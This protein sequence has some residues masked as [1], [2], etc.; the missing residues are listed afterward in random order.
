[1]HDTLAATEMNTLLAALPRKV[2]Q[3]LRPDLLPVT[4]VFGVV[5]QEPGEPI[6]HVYFPLNCLVSLLTV[7]EN[8]LALEVGMVGR[9]GMVGVSLA[10][11]ITASPVRA[12]VQGAGPALQMSAARFMSAFRGSPALQRGLHGYIHRLM[13][14]I[15]QTAAC[16]RFH[17]VEA[18]LAKW[19]LMTRDRVGSGE[20]QMTQEFLSSMLGVRR[21]GVT[22]AASTLQ[23]HGLIEYTRGKIRVLDHAGLEAAACSCY[24]TTA[25]TPAIFAAARAASSATPAA[26]AA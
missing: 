11:G 10:L 12:L 5:L 25:A 15:T 2:Q 23:Q 21:V 7:V 6:H 20:F 4:L 13:G 16:N 8:H 22:E 14:Q 1:M 24:G 18:R 26:F 17:F 3:L 9:E 19:L